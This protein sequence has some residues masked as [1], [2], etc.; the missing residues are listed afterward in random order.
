MPK[1]T[2][3][4]KI[5]GVFEVWARELA[6]NWLKFE[7]SITSFG[8]YDKPDENAEDWGIVHTHNRDSGL[9]AQSNAAV[10]EKA[11]APFLE[12][13]D[14]DILAQ[15]FN[16]WA[17]GWVAGY[18]IR[19]YRDGKIT[20]AALAYFRL[21]QRM[22]DYP[23]LDEEDHSKRELEATL[24]N[25]RD[26]AWKLKNEYLLPDDWES[27]SYAWLSNSDKRYHQRDIECRDD[28]GAYP[29]EEG[30]RAAFEALR[31]EKEPI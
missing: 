22:G 16:H 15:S 27:E 17:C 11:L 14:P 21:K 9:L 10:I 3:V 29:S 6:G 13:D 25:F 23:I 28:D 4:D 19:V 24:V 26:A 20:H 30:L 1:E 31:Y 8:W 12:A 2:E 18:A 5:D 7:M